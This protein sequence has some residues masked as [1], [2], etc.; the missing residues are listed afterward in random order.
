MPLDVE[1]LATA[2]PKV[3]VVKVPVRRVPGTPI[4]DLTQPWP[5]VLGARIRIVELDQTVTTNAEG[6]ATIALPLG[7]TG[8][9]VYT[10]EVTVPGSKYRSVT[11]RRVYEGGSKF[12]LFF[13]PNRDLLL[14]YT[15]ER[16]DESG[17][18]G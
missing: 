10:F 13:D 5:V 15:T 4:L 1:Q 7:P 8:E 2:P 9:A 18:S 16:Y 17:Q 11:R 14:D 6:E 12:S 3:A